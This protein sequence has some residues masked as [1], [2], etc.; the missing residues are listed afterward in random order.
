MRVESEKKSVNDGQIL[1]PNSILAGG[2]EYWS[3]ALF[4]IA[5]AVPHHGSRLNIHADAP[6]VLV[7]WP[8]LLAVANDHSGTFLP[9]HTSLLLFAL[10]APISALLAAQET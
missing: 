4:E 10:W 7:S 3:L 2:A 5:L 9:K 6:S 8:R 1:D